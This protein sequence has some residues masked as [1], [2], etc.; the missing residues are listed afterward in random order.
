MDLS[1]IT[2]PITKFFADRVFGHLP[3]TLVSLLVAVLGALATWLHD[4][5]V[6]PQYQ[7]LV[8]VGLALL[9]AI[10]A[11]YKPAPKAAPPAGFARL[12]LLVLLVVILLGAAGAARAQDTGGP[13]FGGCLANQ[14][15]CFGP[16]VSLSVVAIDLKDGSVTA[17]VS[18]GVGYGVMLASDKWYR[19]GFAAYA[20]FRDTATGQRVVPSVVVSFAEY[21]RLGV[22]VQVG[23]GG[24]PFGLLAIGADFGSVPAGR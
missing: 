22:G 4:L 23:G 6:P 10:G 8:Y 16:S 5:P 14:T 12:G 21:L 11:A 24:T 2:A 18:P 15:T 3:S 20:S 9:A 19:Y 13:K 17:G 7:L 1:F